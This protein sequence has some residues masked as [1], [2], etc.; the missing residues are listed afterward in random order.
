M[1]CAWKEVLSILP[2]RLRSQ[3]DA[4]GQEKGLEIRLRLDKPPQLIR[5]GDSIWLKGNTNQD[6]L[7]YVV[8]M[9]CRYSPWTAA[10]A[11]NGYLTAPGGHRIGLCGEVVMRESNMAGFKSIHSLNIRI[12]RDFTG[13]AKPLSGERGSILIIG[14]PGCGKTTLLRDLIRQLSFR[15]TVGV[16]DERGELFPVGFDRG[17]QMDVIFGCGKPE[18]IECLLRT[19]TPD[20]IAIDEITAQADTIGLMRAAWCG[21]RL[22]AT[23]HA[24]CLQDLKNRE[25]YRPILESKLFQTVIVMKPDKSY[26][27]ERMII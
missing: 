11:S 22:L 21:V 24:S 1:N 7:N 27:I 16:V 12:A 15:E 20:T 14:R 3:V 19:M 17:E 5:K 25:V 4:L 23:A 18:G 13:I 10:S 6:E 8:N 9:A 26:G 2:L